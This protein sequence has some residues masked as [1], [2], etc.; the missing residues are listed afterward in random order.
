[1]SKK[2]IEVSMPNQEKR[3][4]M[5]LNNRYK[6]IIQAQEV[7]AQH[8]QEVIEAMALDCARHYN[9]IFGSVGK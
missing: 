9:R 8:K 1:M 2:P 6:Q 4:E 3:L 7:L 5:E